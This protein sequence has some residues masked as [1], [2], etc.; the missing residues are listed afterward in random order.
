MLIFCSLVSLQIFSSETI[1][2]IKSRYNVHSVADYRAALNTT[3]DLTEDE[4]EIFE[5]EL[6]SDIHFSKGDDL[7]EACC[8][9]LGHKKTAWI[10]FPSSFAEAIQS[11]KDI[12][13]IF[14]TKPLYYAEI[15]VKNHAPHYL[16]YSD[17]GRSNAL[18]LIKYLLENLDEN[19]EIDQCQCEPALKY[20]T[21]KCLG[22]WEED[23]ELFFQNYFF[24]NKTGKSIVDANVDTITTFKQFVLEEWPL[25]GNI[26]FQHIKEQISQ[27][28]DENTNVNKVEADIRNSLK[29]HKNNN[30]TVSLI[31]DRPMRE[32]INRY[33]KF[34]RKFEPLNH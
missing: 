25:E 11:D 8:M 31:L 22:Y 3:D 20:L 26:Q 5:K 1:D 13:T 14:K 29:Q 9:A 32:F 17:D 27:W 28:L 24:F 16:I 12:E 15:Q 33:S 34:F 23:I 2:R 10:D 21:G 18:L 30:V 6:L 19:T 4:D 7:Y